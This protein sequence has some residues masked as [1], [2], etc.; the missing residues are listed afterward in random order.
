MILQQDRHNSEVCSVRCQFCVYNGKEDAIGEKRKRAQTNIAKDWTKPFRTSK[1]REHHI[2]QHKGAWEAYQKLSYDQKKQYFEDRTKH[3]DR[4][5]K[6]FAVS[7]RTHTVYYIDAP[8]VNKIIGEMFF[9][10]DDQ[11]GI[12]HTRALKLFEAD[13]ENSNV[14]S[15]TIKHPMQ[16]NLIVSWLARGVSFR[17]AQD[18]FLSTRRITG[19]M[20]LG[21]L[22]DTDISNY[23]RVVCAINLGKLSGILN[24]NST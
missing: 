15:V 9:Y 5:E 19:V 6:H 10:S 22:N 3:N 18:M 23:A 7:I 16:L 11:H 24:D 1:Y 13:S 12:T 14:Y 20:E 4:I 8:I 17:Q 21:T 2:S